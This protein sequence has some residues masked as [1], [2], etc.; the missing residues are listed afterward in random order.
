MLIFWRTRT[1]THTLIQFVVFSLLLEF[2]L[3][4]MRFTL[5]MFI[6]LYIQG[7]YFF[8]LF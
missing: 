5:K 2:V 6:L 8:K 3:A 1:H 7:G 4:Y